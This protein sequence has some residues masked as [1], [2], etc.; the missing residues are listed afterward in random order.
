MASLSANFLLVT[1]LVHLS[2]V[3]LVVQAEE[4]EE[5]ELETR[6]AK[7]LM[8]KIFNCKKPG[9]LNKAI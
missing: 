1:V 5:A 7:S 9:K 8:R 3:I 2:L 4:E 6:E